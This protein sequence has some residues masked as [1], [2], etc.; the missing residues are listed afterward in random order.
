MPSRTSWPAG[1]C[2]H[3]LAERIQKA[4]NSVPTATRTADEHVQARRHAVPAE[5]QDAEEGRLE[6]EG[7]QHLVAD[8]RP[9]DIADD[10]ARIRL[11]L[12]PNW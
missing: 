6:E 2:I 7:G 4:E 5:E 1:Y 8:E 10:D 11:Q 3:E 12:V 9:D